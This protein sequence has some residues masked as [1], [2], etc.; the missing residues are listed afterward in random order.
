MAEQITH[1]TGSKEE[2]YLSLLPQIKAL[3]EDEPDL[4]ANL[5]N[6][7]AVLKD[8]FNHLWTGF[9]LV[10]SEKELVLGPFQGMLACTRIKT[11]K[12]VC[13]I[14]WEKEK[15]QVVPDVHMFPNHICCDMRSKSEIVV[16]LF[17]DNKVWGVL[18][19]DSEE[20]DTFDKTDEKYLQILCNEIISAK[21]YQ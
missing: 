19:I 16:P 20:F 5:G 7:T 15:I 8:A 10:K 17:K 1:I 13:G 9:Y 12:G 2:I 3:I 21:E 14:A 6:I 11:G 18:D 4:I